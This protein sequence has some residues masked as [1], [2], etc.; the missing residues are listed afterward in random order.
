MKLHH[1]FFLFVALST[2]GC[3][4][5]LHTVMPTETSMIE[6]EGDHAV[7]ASA[8]MSFLTTYAG[9]S[10]AYALPHGIRLNAN[11]SFFSASSISSDGTG[12]ETSQ[13]LL[14][15][16]MGYYRRLH[17]KIQWETSI[18]YSRLTGRSNIIR[19][20][21]ASAF[22][23]NLSSDA[24]NAFSAL[25]FE[26]FN[27]YSIEIAAGYQLINF[28]DLN[29][30]SPINDPTF[31]SDYYAIGSFGHP[32]FTFK[33]CF[34]LENVTLNTFVVSTIQPASEVLRD[35]YFNPWLTGLSLTYTFK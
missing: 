34:I 22:N 26:L 24:M 5:P 29:V 27:F 18:N 28:N 4:A 21:Q 20:S 14:G 19:Q 11:T 17:E 32:V 13:Y 6:E 10:Y 33:H 8:G 15:A 23:A 31:V 30:V 12:E 35:D 7:A 25:R 1:Y 16:G 2:V 3:S 9:V